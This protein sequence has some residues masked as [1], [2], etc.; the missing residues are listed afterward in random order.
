MKSYFRNLMPLRADLA[1]KQEEGEK[2]G[3]KVTYLIYFIK[4]YFN[5]NFKSGKFIK[6]VN[7]TVKST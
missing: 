4:D 5:S 7:T 6:K 2:N 1:N 3:P